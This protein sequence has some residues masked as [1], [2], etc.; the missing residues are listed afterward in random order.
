VDDL[1]A[2]WARAPGLA[3]VARLASLSAA[4]TTALRGPA[5]EPTP[6]LAA[7][8]GAAGWARA[9]TGTARALIFPPDKVPEGAEE[10]MRAAGYTDVLR[11]ATGERA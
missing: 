5:N 11:F 2:E 1:I 7:R 6:A 9:H 4:R 3:T 8:L 10:A